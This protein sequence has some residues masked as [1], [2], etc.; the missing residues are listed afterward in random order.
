MENNIYNAPQSELESEQTAVRDYK[1]YKTSGMGVATFFGTLIAGGYL[2]YRN[3]YLLGRPQQGK[4]ILLT[5]VLATIAIFSIAFMIPEDIPIP[6]T[7]FGIMQLVI[8]I[9]LSKK[10][11]AQ[12]IVDHEDASGE[13][14]SNWRAFGIALLF[15]L[16][17]V[18]IMLIC[19]LLFSP[20]IE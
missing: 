18:V 9:Q 2:A 8:M 12:D 13:M 6:D 15:L 11:F 5:C 16:G 3:C 10:W 19:I 4:N 20:F 1:L 14:Y 7:A 17:L